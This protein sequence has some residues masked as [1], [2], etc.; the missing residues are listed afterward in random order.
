[1][2]KRYFI[3]LAYNGRNFHGWQIQPNAITVQETLQDALKILLKQKIDVIGCGRTDT[4]VHARQFFAHM[5]L[6]LDTIEVSVDQLTYK[7]NRLL[8]NDIAIFRIFIVNDAAH[9][10]FEALSRTYEYRLRMDKYPFDQEFTYRSTYPKLDFELMNKAAA[11]LFNYTDF[12]SFSKTGTDVK[13]NNCKIMQADW[14]NVDGVWIFTIKADRFLRNM[15][16]AIVGTLLEVGSG[17]IDLNNFTQIIES[18][19]RSN[20]GWSVPAHGLALIKLEYPDWI[21]SV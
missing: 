16:R 6:D 20:A 3:E 19:N 18:K 13:T 10:R 17:K 1:M 5:E 11:L 14:K 8:N 4:G 15:V 7:L 21:Y 2:S 12:T 9:T